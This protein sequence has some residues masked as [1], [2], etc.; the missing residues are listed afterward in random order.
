MQE[1][2]TSECPLVAQRFNGS[3]DTEP[4]DGEG[5]SALVDVLTKGLI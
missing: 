5:V 2:M 4:V 3:W 1:V